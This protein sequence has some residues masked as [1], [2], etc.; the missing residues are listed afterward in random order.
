MN[1][2]NIV[3]GILVAIG[4]MAVAIFLGIACYAGLDHNLAIVLGI[5]SGFIYGI[6]WSLKEGNKK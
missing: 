3:Y 6:V 1:K 2:K 5:A 4:V